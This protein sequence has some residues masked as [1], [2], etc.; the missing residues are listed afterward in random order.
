MENKNERAVSE[1]N[2]GLKLKGFNVFQIED[3]TTATRV[4]SRKDFYKIC[5]T[6]GKSIIHYA[7]RSYKTDGTVLFFGNPNIPYSWETLSTS[8]VGY[9][10]LFS[11]DFLK[12]SDRSDSLQQSP[13]FRI[14]GTPVLNISEK[15]RGF[16]NTIFLK[17]IEEQQTDYPYKDD[18]IRNYINLIIHEALKLQPSEISNQKDNAALRLTTVFLELL[19]RQFPVES[20][21]RQLQLKTAQDYA[22]NLNVH[23]NYLNR[24]VKKI[25]GKS[26]T[27][28]I[29]ERIAS[30]AK[31]LLQHTDWNIADIAYAL[32]FEY[33]SYFNNFFK[34]ITSTNPTSFRIQKV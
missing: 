3:D 23:A 22:N 25:T 12:P 29:S 30:E 15:Q 26:T 33:P 7:D 32:G 11:E 1:F 18:L 6:T 19:E 20:T 14:G 24:A 8:Y 5:L 17:M 21:D 9:T 13:L 16:L 2:S 34:K 31:A 10:C 27:T 28:H 4:Y